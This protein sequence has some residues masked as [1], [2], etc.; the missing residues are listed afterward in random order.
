MMFL[1]PEKLR[2][3]VELYREVYSQAKPF[4]IVIDNFYPSKFWKKC[5]MNFQSQGEV[6]W[7]TS[8]GLQRE[9]AKCLLAQTTW[10]K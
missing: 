5:S 8:I 6:N 4:H 1:D 7:Y 10:E 9:S 2:N 3:F